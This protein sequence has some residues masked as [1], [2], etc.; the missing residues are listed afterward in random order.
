M[1][2]LGVIGYLLF[3]IALANYAAFGIVKIAVL[4]ALLIHFGAIV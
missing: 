2:A 4:A 1:L 3:W